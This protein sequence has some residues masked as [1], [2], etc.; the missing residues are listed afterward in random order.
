MKK[1]LS[2]GA[3]TELDKQEIINMQGGVLY[4]CY[5]VLRNKN[6]L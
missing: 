5:T 3:F 1:T 2:M 6:Q 4:S